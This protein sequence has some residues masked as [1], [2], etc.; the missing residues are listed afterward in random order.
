MQGVQL[1]PN[2]KHI[3]QFTKSQISYLG[4]PYTACTT[5][6]RPDMSILFEKYSADYQYSQQVCNTLC[7]QAFTYMQCNCTDSD[8]WNYNNVYVDNEVVSTKLCPSLS[9]CIQQAKITFNLNQAVQEQYCSHCLPECT[10]VNY[11]IMS[12]SLK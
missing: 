1:E 9:S 2:R 12:S 8:I 5:E 3:L 4:S 10:I 6:I 11:N 7:E